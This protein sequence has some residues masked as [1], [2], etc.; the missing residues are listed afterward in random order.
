MTWQIEFQQALKSQAALEKYFD[1]SFPKV[2]YPI[3]LPL[4]M[5]KKIKKSGKDSPFMES[6]YSLPS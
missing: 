1:L 2:N 6:I 5:A 3:F 4:E